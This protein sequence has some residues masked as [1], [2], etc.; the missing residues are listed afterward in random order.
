MGEIKLKSVALTASKGEDI[1][2]REKDNSQLLFRPIIV[3]NKDEPEA[4][5]K[6]AII[7][8]KKDDNGEYKEEENISDL[9]KVKKGQFAKIDLR[10]EDILVLL[11]NFEMLKE[12]Y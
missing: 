5:V 2:I 11:Q 12:L 6:G 4:C 8:R 7:Y 1:I 10:S 9:R 3:N